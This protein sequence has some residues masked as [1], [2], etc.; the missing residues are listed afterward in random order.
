[1]L[2]FPIGMLVG[3]FHDAGQAGHHHEIRLGAKVHECSDP[4]LAAWAFAHGPP[5]DAEPPWTSVALVRHMA[6]LG[7]A[8]PGT[9]VAGLRDRGLLAELAPD[10]D[11]ATAFARSH[12]LVPA[13]YGLGNSA[14][15]PWLYSIGLLGHEMVRVDRPVFELWAW[16]DTE[17]DL[18]HACESFAAG[19]V[20]AGGQEPEVTEPGRVLAG[21]LGTLH[22]LLSVQAAHLDTIDVERRNGRRDG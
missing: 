21:F 1:M 17:P 6:G 18:W 20:A 9:I 2:V 12:R 5:E 13:M 4:E 10:T 11:A 19:E 3:T 16:S 8:E 15:E 14:D 7:I 22:G